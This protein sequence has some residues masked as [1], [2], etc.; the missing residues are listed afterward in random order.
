[1]NLIVIVFFVIVAR[2]SG[3][4]IT[5]SFDEQ[6]M[7][8]EVDLVPSKYDILLMDLPAE[9]MK[10]RTKE[11]FGFAYNSE[12][13]G[14]GTFPI[15]G[16]ILEADTLRVVIPIVVRHKKR[17]IQTTCLVDTTSPWTFMSRETLQAI[18]I[19]DAVEPVNIAVQGF[20]LP[21]HIS[22]NHFAGINICGQSFFR[23]HHLIL[24]VNYVTLKVS[25]VKR[26]EML[27]VEEVDEL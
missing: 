18:G 4:W 17:A 23:T 2:I 1:M 11:A 26:E 24:S 19:V 3:I 9:R 10:Q 12:T 22:A 13:T 7:M 8:E 5:G 14:A 15:E 27:T 25:V 6:K 20:P 21:V 16:D